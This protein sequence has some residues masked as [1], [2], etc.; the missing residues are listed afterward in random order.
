MLKVGF[1][2]LDI[3]PPLGNHM[4]GY[5]Q[6]NTDKTRLSKGVRQPLLLNTLAISN[7]EKTIHLLAAD[8]IGIKMPCIKKMRDLISERT[9]IPVNDILISALHQHTSAHIAEDDNDWE[10]IVDPIFFDVM[11]R[12]FADGAAMAIDDM[13]PATVSTGER[14]LE[15]PISFVRRYFTNEGV[16]TNPGKCKEIYSRCA[17]AD[18]TVRIVRI[19]REGGND[20]A[21]IN[22]ATHPDT[23]AG[24]LYDA[25]WPGYARR[26]TEAMLPGVSAIT[27]VGYQGDTNHLDYFI[28]RKDWPYGL[29]YT[30]YMGESIADAVVAIWDKTEKTE[31][32]GVFAE[33]KVVYNRTN[34]NGIEDYDKWVKFLD[35]YFAGRL[36]YDPSLNEMGVAN[37]IA[38][39]K[40]QPIFRP[41]PITV[42]KFAG[43]LW[44]GLGGEPFTAYR[45]KIQALAKDTP[46]I[47]SIC[48]N[49][50]EGYF[51]TTEAFNQGGYE[52]GGSNFTPTLEDEILGAV[53]ELIEKVK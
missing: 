5:F 48:T 45:A 31:G 16:R 42:M 7:D 46:L 41:I 18:N 30:L 17:E 39:I 6:K 23:L 43:V 4:A 26:Y 53:S 3:T 11:Y 37:R 15:K 28:P 10:A 33:Y 20:I 27:F 47:C 44:V 24:N 34:L 1:S 21:V 22:F 51:P 49:G 50:Y 52:A 29:D 25:D 38:N 14:E 32:D 12:K 2:R 35:D 13:K 40:K 8:Y 36:G 19:S 9:G